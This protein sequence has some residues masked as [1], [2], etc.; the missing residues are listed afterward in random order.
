MRK[1]FRFSI[2]A[3]L[4]AF[5][6]AGEAN[7][8]DISEFQFTPSQWAGTCGT[9][10]NSTS[11]IKATAYQYGCAGIKNS[12]PFKIAKRQTYLV[13]RGTKLVSGTNNPCLYNFNDSNL[14]S[15]PLF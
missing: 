14:A 12:T 8:T 13:V 7:A 15:K 1:Y 9:V 10:D 11:I 5:V 6:S 4:F 2:V 3:S